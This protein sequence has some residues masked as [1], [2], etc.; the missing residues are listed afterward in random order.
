MASRHAEHWW[1]FV[2]LLLLRK[3]FLHPAERLNIALMTGRHAEHSSYNPQTKKRK[4]CETS[5]SRSSCSNIKKAKDKN[6][7]KH[8]RYYTLGC[9]I[10]DTITFTYKPLIM[11]FH[12]KG[13]EE[14]CFREPIKH[15]WP[16]QQAL[17]GLPSTGCRWF[18][19]IWGSALHGL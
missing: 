3:L 10:T 11:H 5:S 7:V 12:S 2:K 16:W 9:E 8:A 19:H 4:H 14:L 18:I 6:L 15:S 13:S 1:T 17:M